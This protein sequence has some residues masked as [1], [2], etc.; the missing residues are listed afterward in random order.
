MYTFGLESQCADGICGAGTDAF[1]AEAGPTKALR[2][3]K[4]LAHA[5]YPVGPALAGKASGVTPHTL[6]DRL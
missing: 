4:E 6:W 3:P 5:A 1:P 2:T